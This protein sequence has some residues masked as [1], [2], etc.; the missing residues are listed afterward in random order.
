MSRTASQLAA[1]EPG[2]EQSRS[3]P[4]IDKRFLQEQLGYLRDPSPRS[5]Y[6]HM[7]IQETLD[8]HYKAQELHENQ[9]KSSKIH[10]PSSQP[11]SS[12][13]GSQRAAKKPAWNRVKVSTKIHIANPFGKRLN[14][15]SS[16]PE[17]VGGGGGSL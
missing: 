7:K 8:K 16:N 5:T 2:S 15:R 1:K 4:G 14:I 17:E 6:V 11:A 13:G 9:C 12:Q 3:Q 10:Q